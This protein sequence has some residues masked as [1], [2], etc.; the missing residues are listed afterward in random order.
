CCPG[1]P[2]AVD[3]STAFRHRLSRP[4]PIRHRIAD[5]LLEFYE[6]DDDTGRGA[7]LLHTSQLRPGPTWLPVA[8]MHPLARA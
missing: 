4:A 1:P 3:T 6:K 8:G 5:Y 2:R 7:E